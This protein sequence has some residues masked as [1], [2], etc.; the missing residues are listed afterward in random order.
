MPFTFSH[1]IA[2]IPFA[3]FGLPISALVIGSMTPDF[4]YFLQLS[5]GNQ[6]G[7]SVRGLLLFC[8]PAGLV[9]L[10]LWHRVL[11]VALRT[12]L[13]FSWQRK[14]P[15]ASNAFPFW[16]AKQML[17]IVG[18]LLIGATTHVV[19]D[20]LTHANGFVVRHWA[21]LRE[22][23]FTTSHG[24]IYV[25]KFLQHGSSLLGAIALV[26]LCRRE[27]RSSPTGSNSRE[28]NSHLVFPMLFFTTICAMF[29]TFA[30]TADG[31]SQSQIRDFVLLFIVIFFIEL[32]AWSVWWHWK[33]RT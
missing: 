21:P 7:H 27:M 4:P 1:P 15:R 33:Q 19:W 3:R 20:S 11:V 14:L 26:W 8:V 31:V 16:P 32:T 29:G 9:A 17:L 2:V 10:W 28:T 5:T 23:L 30:K 13:P 24:T 12:L 6:F 18:A 22:P 25:F